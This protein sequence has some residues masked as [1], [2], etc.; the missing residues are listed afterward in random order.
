MRRALALAL[1][2]A[3]SALANRVKD[4]LASM[5]IE[6]KVGAHTC[7]QHAHVCVFVWVWVH[8]YG[9]VRTCACL[10]P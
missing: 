3:G 1:V 6:Q 2:A 4:L 5:T 7:M 9:C 10:V 8:V